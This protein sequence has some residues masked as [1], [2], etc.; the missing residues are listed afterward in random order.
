MYIHLCVQLCSVQ[1]CVYDK[2]YN[3]M[4]EA[5]AAILFPINCD[6]RAYSVVLWCYADN[7]KNLLLFIGI[8]FLLLSQLH[9]SCFIS[10]VTQLVVTANPRNISEYVVLTLK[11]HAFR[12]RNDWTL[13][14]EDQG[15]KLR[16]IHGAFNRDIADCEWSITIAFVYRG[17]IVH[18]PHIP[19]CRRST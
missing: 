9:A 1:E 16:S 13:K 8:L 11:I 19:Q 18:T 3:I 2:Y 12:K 17:I 14:F 15:R 7:D 6:N 4:L 10:Y 5:P